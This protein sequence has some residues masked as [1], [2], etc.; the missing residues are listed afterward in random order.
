MPS[1]N[2]HPFWLFAP[3]SSN[4]SPLKP[5]K[6]VKRC[7]FFWGSVLNMLSG[8]FL[9]VNSLWVRSG[10]PPLEILPNKRIWQLERDSYFGFQF[11][12]IFFLVFQINASLENDRKYCIF[13]WLNWIQIYIL[14]SLMYLNLIFGQEDTYMVVSI[15]GTWHHQWICHQRKCCLV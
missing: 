13:C 3:K 15:L 12:F 14:V 9:L 6:H 1:L 11:Y 5:W 7:C 8:V 4:S 10:D 2:K